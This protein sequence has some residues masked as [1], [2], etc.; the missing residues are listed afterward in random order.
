MEAARWAPSCNNEQPWRFLICSRE[1]SPDARLAVFDSL[2]E[3]NQK[4]C[5]HVPTFV[6]VVT[7]TRFI[8]SDR[9]NPWATYDAGSAALSICLQATEMGLMARQMAGFESSALSVA[10]NIPE[11]YRPVS[12]IAIGYQ[13]P[14][15]DIPK[16]MLE[17][18]AAPRVRKGLGEIRSHGD[19]TFR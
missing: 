13:L 14:I 16:E 18:E 19:W 12:V 10:F 1:D 4:W 5:V 3:L 2:W 11:L 17:Q 7:R 9:E 6:V 15:Q 8:E